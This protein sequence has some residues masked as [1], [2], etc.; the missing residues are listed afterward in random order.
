MTKEQILSLIELLA[1]I[2]VVWW[3]WD[4]APSSCLSSDIDDALDML[5]EEILR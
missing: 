1:G 2:K 3:H 5:K 4:Q